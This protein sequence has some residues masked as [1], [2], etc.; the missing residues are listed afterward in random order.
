[1]ASVCTAFNGRMVIAAT[2]VAAIALGYGPRARATPASWV[3]QALAIAH[4]QD[5]R[6]S[7]AP[8]VGRYGIDE[9]GVFVFD[10]SSHR[11]LLKFDDSPE[12]WVLS[13]SHG[14]RGDIIYKNDLGEPLLRATK[15][16]GMTV[17]TR[18]RPEGSAA[19]LLGPST[20]LRLATI[21][22]IA[23]FRYVAQA[24]DRSSRAAQH[25]IEFD[26]P[27]V[28]PASDGLIA[29]TA[30]V[31]MQAVVNLSTRPGGKAALA[32]VSTIVFNE[33]GKSS[34]SFRGGA[35][36][37]TVVPAQGLA[38]RPSSVRI[39]QAMAPR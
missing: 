36:T 31:A 8:P 29:D 26:V 20:P 28:G 27:D 15:L 21:G 25:R 10:R 22:P 14:P 12:V 17:F 7:A 13:P 34:V 1:M 35:L 2:L 3:K 5:G 23:L 37:V 9:G 4:G 18:R 11:P 38:G 16:G 39:L 30:I 33:G 24:S 6:A 19:A 32:H